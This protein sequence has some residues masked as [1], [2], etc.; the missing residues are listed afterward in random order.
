MLAREKNNEKRPDNINLPFNSERP[1]MGKV[2][3]KIVG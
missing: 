3:C 2:S 1:E